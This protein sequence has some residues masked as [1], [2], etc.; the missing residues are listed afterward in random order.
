MDVRGPGAVT[1]TPGALQDGVQ[2]YCYVAKQPGTYTISA[3]V[4]G[5]VGGCWG[6]WWRWGLVA[7]VP[8]SC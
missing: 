2:T 7:C 3:T 4:D 1:V 5:Q 6:V 8:H